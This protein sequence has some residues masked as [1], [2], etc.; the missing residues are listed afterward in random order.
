MLTA[1]RYQLCND[2][3]ILPAVQGGTKCLYHNTVLLKLCYRRCISPFEG[4]SVGTISNST[5]SGK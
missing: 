5:S 4:G 2:M 3:L 1:N